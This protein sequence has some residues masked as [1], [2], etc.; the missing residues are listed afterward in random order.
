MD[1]WINGWMDGW[2]DDVASSDC[3]ATIHCRVVRFG[4]HLSISL[5]IEQYINLTE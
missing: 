3:L 4:I 2:M 5:S 1:G